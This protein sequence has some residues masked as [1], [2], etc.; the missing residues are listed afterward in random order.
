MEHARRYAI[1]SLLDT[2]NPQTVSKIV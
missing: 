2:L 1:G